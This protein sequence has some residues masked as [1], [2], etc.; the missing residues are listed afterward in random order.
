[1]SRANIHRYAIYAALL[2]MLTGCDAES[3]WQLHDVS[4]HLP[5][6][7]FAL[8]SDRG[9]TVTE[10][11]YRGYQIMLFFGFTDC[12]SE[13]PVTLFRLA[14]IVQ[15]LGKDGNRIRILFVSLVPA[16]DSPQ[17]LRRYLSGFDAEHAIGLTG[18]TDE[19]EA[20]AK[21]YRAAYRPGASDAG[22]VTHSAAVYVFDTQGHA[23]LLVTPDDAIETVVNDVRRLASESGP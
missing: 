13:C 1:M 20:L 12:I 6:L 23:R 2:W 14:K 18:G 16:R 7:Q 17:V 21:R 8:T 11:N 3:H 4:G 15:R 10:Q 5:D 19:I 22:N 9:E